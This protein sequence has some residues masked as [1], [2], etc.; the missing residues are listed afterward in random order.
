MSWSLMGVQGLMK[1]STSMSPILDC[2]LQGSFWSMPLRN[3][4]DSK[5]NA[6]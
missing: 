2:R 4:R 3:L 5:L 6:A 1:Q